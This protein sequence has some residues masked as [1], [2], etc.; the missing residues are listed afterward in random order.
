MTPEQYIEHEVQLRLNNHKF[1]I[2]DRELNRLNSKLN[3]I[4][5]TIMTGFLLP[6]ILHYFKLI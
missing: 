3:F 6:V 1:N 2:T 5:I 4:I